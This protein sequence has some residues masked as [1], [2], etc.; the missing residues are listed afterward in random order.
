VAA[1]AVVVSSSMAIVGCTHTVTGTARRA[2]HPDDPS[3]SYAFSENRCGLLQD[4]S[5]RQVVGA[6]KSTRPY[7][8][9]VCQY[10]L[11]RQGTFID[12]TFSWFETG[13]LDREKGL[14]QQD[15]AQITDIVLAHHQ[16]FLAQRSVTGN[17]CSATAATTPGVVSWWVQI[18]GG[19]PGDPCKDAQNLLSKTLSSDM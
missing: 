18:R 9:A 10:V 19:A 3:H 15:K 4:S 11:S 8:G 1:I 12:V 17:A 16:V 5:V 2:A 13:T 14:A 6:D 7:S